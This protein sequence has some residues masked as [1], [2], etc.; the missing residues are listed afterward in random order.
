MFYGCF[1]EKGGNLYTYTNMKVYITPKTEA[2]EAIY[3]SVICHSNDGEDQQVN[4][5]PGSG[6]G[7]KAAPGRLF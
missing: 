4:P 1:P 6:G 5:T 7:P 3:G 2:I